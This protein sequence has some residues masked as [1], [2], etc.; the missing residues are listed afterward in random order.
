MIGCAK[1]AISALLRLY[2]ALTPS[3]LCLFTLINATLA[4][5]PKTFCKKCRIRSLPNALL[6]DKLSSQSNS[7]LLV[8]SLKERVGM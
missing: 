8:F 7:L 3:F 2:D 1:A 4:G 6:A 5:M